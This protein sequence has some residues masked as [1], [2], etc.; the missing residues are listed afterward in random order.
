MSTRTGPPPPE[1]RGSGA[2]G[3][4]DALR[5]GGGI[6]D[7]YRFV[8]RA[9]R[10]ATGR[11]NLP[12]PEGRK[13]DEDSYNDVA[14]DFFA[15][16]T[17]TK[18]VSRAADDGDL[19]RMTRV[20]VKNLVRSQ[21][22]QTKRGKLHRRLRTI[23]RETDDFIED[24]AGW[25]GLATWTDPGVLQRNEY[26]LDSAAW[27]VD[28]TVPYWRPDAK[29]EGP[30]AD[31]PSFISMV[32]AILERAD[33]RV[34]I[35]TL[36]RVVADRFGLPGL[37]EFESIDVPN[38]AGD[39]TYRREPG[40]TAA[41]VE[42]VAVAEEIW[43]HQLSDRERRRIPYLDAGGREIASDLGDRGKSAEDDAIKRLQAKLRTL[44]ADLNDADRGGVVSHLRAL[45]LEQVEGQ[46]DNEGGLAVHSGREDT[47]R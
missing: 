34:D 24:P 6:E 14:Q 21:L 37:P 30:L 42:A 36:V 40:D 8:L 35:G 47:I 22:R 29:Y 2:A 11:G 44:L 16:D 12:H 4:L 5:G 33:A 20:A 31:R 39:V 10:F 46:P 38:D 1:P 9:V 25:W 27:S 15:K 26:E 13:W 41:S 23:L 7:Y 43:L 18:I 45:A 17:H 3:L 28:V 32:I 19:S